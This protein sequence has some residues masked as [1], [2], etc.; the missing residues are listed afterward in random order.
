MPGGIPGPSESLGR[1]RAS[2]VGMSVV[3]MAVV[4]A[5]IAGLVV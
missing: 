4:V 5:V 2:L 3:A 1:D